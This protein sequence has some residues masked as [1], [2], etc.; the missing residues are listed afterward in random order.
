MVK[1]PK[2]RKDRDGVHISGKFYLAPPSGYRLTKWDI[3]TLNKR[4]HGT[5]GFSIDI[6]GSKTGSGG[7]KIYL[8]SIT[9]GGTVIG[10][11]L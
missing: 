5:Q 6:Y 11:Y 8:V 3:E 4:D 1:K 9:T 7:K 2:I 10:T